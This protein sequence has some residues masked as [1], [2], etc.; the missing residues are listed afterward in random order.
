MSERVS[1]IIQQI[2]LLS[3]DE[4]QEVRSALEVDDAWDVQMRSDLASGKLDDLLQQVDED[5]NNQ[6]C[7]AFP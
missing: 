3:E 7:R 6:R 4:L 5:L 1:K 2:R